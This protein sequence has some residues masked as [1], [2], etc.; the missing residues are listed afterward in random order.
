MSDNS[1]AM[2]STLVKNILKLKTSLYLPSA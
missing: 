1:L 2:T